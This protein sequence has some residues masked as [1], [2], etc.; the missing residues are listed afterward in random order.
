VVGCRRETFKG[1]SNGDARARKKYD[2][3]H[4]GY[5]IFLGRFDGRDVRYSGPSHVYVNGPTR[6]GKSVGFVL[7]NAL[8]WRGSLIGLDIKREM[9]AEIAAARVQMGQKVFLFSTGSEE[10]H[11]RNTLDLVALWPARATDVANIARS[12]GAGDRRRLLG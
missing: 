9:W 10:T 5:S 7:P 6:A 4:S 11:R 8:E 12:L 2:K 3:K 1:A